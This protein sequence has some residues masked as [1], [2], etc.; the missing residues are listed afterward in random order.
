MAIRDE[1][2]VNQQPQQAQPQAQQAQPQTSSSFIFGRGNPFGASISMN[3][4]SEYTNKLTT[5]L[6]EVLKQVPQEIEL[7]AISIDNT[8]DQRLAFS[9]IIVA[10]RNKG[11]KKVAYH[12]LILE[13]TGEKLQP[14]MENISGVAVEILRLPSDA[15]DSVLNNISVEMLSKEFP[16]CE[17]LQVDA[18]V[19][20]KGFNPEDKLAI[21]KLAANAANAT[22]NELLVDAPGFTDLSVTDIKDRLNINLEFTRGIQFTDSVGEPVRSD[23]TVRFETSP[24]QQQNKFAVNTQ[25]RATAVSEVNGFVDFLWV[26]RE[27]MAAMQQMSMQNPYMMTP[28]KFAARLVLTNISSNVAYTPA[29]LMLYI[30]SSMVLGDSNNWM[31]AFRPSTDNSDIHN[32]A[33]LNIEG[34][35]ERKPEGFG[36]KPNMTADAFKMEDFYRF[37]NTLVRPGMIVSVDV[38]EAGPQTWYE[39]LFAAASIGSKTAYDVIYNACNQLTGGIFARYFNRNEAM[40]A[41]TSE[42]VHLGYYINKQGVKKDI[43][44]I[45]YLVVANMLGESNPKAI[46]DWSDTFTQDQYPEVMRL[47]ARKRFIRTLTS[48]TAEFTGYAQRITFSAKL[49]QALSQSIRETGLTVNVINP[50]AAGGMVVERGYASYADQAI[51]TPGI[52]FAQRPSFQQGSQ[53]PTWGTHR[54]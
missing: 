36:E 50:I 27:G 7:K 15:M 17:L 37:L 51:M 9:V 38:P 14:I 4:G 6:N 21:Q 1:S 16:G 53:A 33:S 48:E 45:D 22:G 35:V 47:S 31:L 24:Q 12:T 43:R 19:V 49:L 46:R 40:F 54:W 29:A 39:S 18:C 28:Q 41:S 44:D 23:V 10:Q 13:S 32:V 20:P 5:N 11:T 52:T 25:Q 2:N 42:R 26:H 34:N 30:A 3:T 8:V